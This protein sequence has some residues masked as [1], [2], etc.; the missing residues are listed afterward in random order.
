MSSVDYVRAM[1]GQSAVHVPAWLY[2]Q[3][4]GDGVVSFV[5][6]SK[7]VPVAGPHPLRYGSGRTHQ[8]LAGDLVFRPQ[9]VVGTDTLRG[10]GLGGLA[11]GGH[12]V[13]ELLADGEIV[14]NRITG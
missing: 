2:V 12:S 9:L 1:F 7:P 11:V 6:A 4:Q 13:E 8:L 5:G 10:A 14:L 3:D